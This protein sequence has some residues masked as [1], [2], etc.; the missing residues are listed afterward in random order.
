MSTMTPPRHYPRSVKI[1]PISDIWPLKLTDQKHWH[2]AVFFAVRNLVRRTSLQSPIG[3]W[4]SLY[5]FW[6]HASERASEE[7]TATNE[8]T[9]AK[10]QAGANERDTKKYNQARSA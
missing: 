7:A 2:F 4:F 1:D 10:T 6:C 9:N 3:D 5:I 8:R